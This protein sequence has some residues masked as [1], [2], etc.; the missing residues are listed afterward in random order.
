MEF[1]NRLNFGF[2][3]IA[4]FCLDLAEIEDLNDR[5]R[6]LEA[7][8]K[9]A[10]IMSGPD[11]GEDKITLLLGAINDIT[12]NIKSDTD[13]KL[14]DFV[15]QNTFDDLVKEQG[16]LYRRVQNLEKLTKGLED[17]LAANIQKIDTNRKS[18]QRNA[19]EI[20]KLKKQLASGDFKAPDKGEEE[21]GE[22][23][24]EEEVGGD[25]VGKL[26]AL[27]TRT[28][29][30]L[31]QRIA[32]CEDQIP[33]IQQHGDN[34]V[35]LEL[36]I[37]RVNRGSVGGAAN[38]GGI[39]ASQEEIDSWT[40][41]A[42]KLPEMDAELQQL[43]RDMAG[44]DGPKIKA[45]ILQLFKV[46]ANVGSKDLI[47][48]LKEDLRRIK[49]ELADSAYEIT[50]TREQIA[51]TDKDMKK[52]DKDIRKDTATNRAKIDTLEATINAL[53]KSIGNENDKKRRLAEAKNSPVGSA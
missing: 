44:L 38:T 5:L 48:G 22:E 20:E 34:I 8:N 26:Q 39:G 32:K 49:Q 9:I 3:N 23:A 24:E 1:H 21:D 35:N 28:E 11:M 46:T 6:K 53:K 41:A 31:V 12:D 30:Q 36:K 42:G 17:D 14:E 15:R 40:E 2:I 50:N 10:S 51:K 33:K 43:K 47:D 29:K 16:G 13:K 52:M 45:D 37:E 18:C 25:A 27:I 19:K 4:C 7:N